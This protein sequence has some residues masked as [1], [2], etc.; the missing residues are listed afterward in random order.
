MTMSNASR[1]DDER[2]PSD[3]DDPDRTIPIDARLIDIIEDKD[4]DFPSELL[5]CGAAGTG[6][7]YGILTVLHLLAK[8][9]PGLRILIARNY[10]ASLT[11]SVVAQFEEEILPSDSYEFITGK[12]D[13]KNRTRYLYPNTARIVLGGIDNWERYKSTAWDIVFINEATELALDAWEGISARLNRPGTKAGFGWLIGD[14]NPADPMHPLKL[15]CDSGLCEY[16][17]TGHEANPALYDE[18]EQDWTEDGLIYLDRLNRLTGTAYQRL[19]LGLWAAGEGAW[20]AAYDD[21]NDVTEHADYHPDKGKVH[22][23]V[24]CNGKHIG[25]VWF[26]IR[27]MHNDPKICV[28]GDY[29]SE[30][31]AKH[32]AKHAADILKLSHKL[33]DH[34]IDR[35]TGDPSGGQHTGVNTTVDAEYRKAGLPLV[36]WPKFGGSVKSGLDLIETFLGGNL[37]VHKRCRATRTALLNFRRKM[38]QKQW[39][40]EPEDPQHPHEDVIEALRGG[41]LDKWPNGRRPDLKLRKARVTHLG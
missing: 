9:N 33:C 14:T 26:Q 25:A 4:Y 15:R 32:A 5:I 27:D 38:R 11:E 18:E 29:Y 35:M 10:R 12:G 41:L 22:L 31:P 16:W 34:R 20:F 7:T 13:R 24:D 19:A 36:H 30:D 6:K 3:L 21:R 23:A 28:F 2:L 8:Q 17:D 37:L 39:I 40:D 1:S